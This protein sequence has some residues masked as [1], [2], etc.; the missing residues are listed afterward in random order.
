MVALKQSLNSSELT[1]VVRANHSECTI[2]LTAVLHKGIDSI[3][4]F[5]LTLLS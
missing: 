4:Y 3:T 5:Y 1:D 2:V